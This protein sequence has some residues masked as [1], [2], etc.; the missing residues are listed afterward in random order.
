MLGKKTDSW[1]G[2]DSITGEKQLELNMDHI[3][4]H[5]PK[6][7]RNTVYL[8]RTLYNILMYEAHTGNQWNISFSEYATTEN[9]TP[10]LDYGK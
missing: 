9:A 1:V 7:S 2:I 3:D 5:C 10:V 6:P 8:G 4:R